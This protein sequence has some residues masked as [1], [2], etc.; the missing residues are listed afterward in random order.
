MAPIHSIGRLAFG[1]ALH[2]SLSFSFLEI[3]RRANSIDLEEK[4][5]RIEIDKKKK[6]FKN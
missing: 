2:S 1:F 6:T 3:A 4:P 5:N